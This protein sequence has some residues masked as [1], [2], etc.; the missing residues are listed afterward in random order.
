MVVGIIVAGTWLSLSIVAVALC[1][2]AGQSAD[3]MTTGARIED[4]VVRPAERVPTPSRRRAPASSGRRAGTSRET[5]S[6]VLLT[7]H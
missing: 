5:P 7:P 1:R 6:G 2:V 3:D 4:V